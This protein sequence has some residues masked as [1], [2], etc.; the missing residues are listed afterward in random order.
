VRVVV[1]GGRAV[2]AGRLAGLLQSRLVLDMPDPL[3]LTLAGISPSAAAVRRPPGRA[4]D[5]RDEAEIQLAIGDDESEELARR[6]GPPPEGAGPWRVLPLP[7]VVEGDRVP[8]DVPDA[9]FVGVG[10]DDL[11]PLGFDLARDERR[12]VVAGPPRSGRST[13]LETIASRLLAAGRVVAVITTR[14]STLTELVGG[15]R[16]H[17]LRP[18]EVDRFVEL[19]RA[20]PDLGIVVD[21]AEGLDGNAIETAL[22][23]ATRLVDQAEGVV[24]IAV[25]SRRASAAFR[26]IVPEVARAGTGLLLQPT[27]PADGDLFR[28][29][30]EPSATR[31]PGRGL[32]LSDGV[33]TGIQVA[34]PSTAQPSVAHPLAALPDAAVAP[35]DQPPSS[36]R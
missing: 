22:V 32:H 14:R 21:D 34:L 28:I 18:G 17:V 35:L 5:V 7:E 30:V 24:A 8:V 19:R 1:S 3:D 13:A 33:A 12:I 16:L 23:E 9:L 10:G 20:H 11:V 15:S 26:G 31:R 36:S 4:Y 29:R 27:T 2:A 6:W 25:D